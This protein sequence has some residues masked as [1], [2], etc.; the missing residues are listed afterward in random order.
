MNSSSERIVLTYTGS[1]PLHI[2]GFG[3]VS[4]YGDTLVVNNRESA[5]RIL[6]FHDFQEATAV[7]EEDEE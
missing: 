6:H 7:A 2:V 5:D 3:S 1:K 4:E